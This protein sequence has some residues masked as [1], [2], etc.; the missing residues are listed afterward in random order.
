MVANKVRRTKAHEFVYIRLC[1]LDFVFL[2]LYYQNITFSKVGEKTFLFENRTENFYAALHVLMSRLDT[3]TN[4][5]SYGPRS[6]YLRWPL[7]SL[8]LSLPLFFQP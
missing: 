4:S 1:A 8:E 6:V 2:C 3:Q 7:N 5:F